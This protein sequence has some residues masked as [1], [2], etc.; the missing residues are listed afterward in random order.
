MLEW[1]GEMAAIG[2]AI[3]ILWIYLEWK[4]RQKRPK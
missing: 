3:G 2:L 1:L 4:I